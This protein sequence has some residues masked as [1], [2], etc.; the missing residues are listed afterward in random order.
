MIFFKCFYIFEIRLCQ[1]AEFN[2]IFLSKR[3]IFYDRIKENSFGWEDSLMD[4]QKHFS[5]YNTA[6]LH[7]L[8][9]THEDWLLQR[10][11][12][13]VIERGFGKYVPPLIESWRLAIAGVSESILIGLHDL[14]PEFEIGPDDDY[15][16]DPVSRFAILEAHRHRERGITLKMF[17]GLLIYF[18]QIFVDL[19]QYAEFELGYERYSKKIIERLFDRMLLAL[20][21]EWTKYD[22]NKLIEDL[23]A[24]NRLM[25]NEKNKYLSIFESHPHLVFILDNENRIDNMNHSAATLFYNAKLPGSQYYRVVKNGEL[26]IPVLRVSP[27]SSVEGAMEKASSEELFP[28]LA[29]E[30][31]L[32][33][34]GSDLIRGFE[35]KVDGKEGTQYFNVK[36]SR[37]IDARKEIRGIILL[38][39]DITPQK[40]VSEELRQAKE[41]AERANRAKSTF[42]ANM[43]H[44]LRTPLNAILG[45]TRMMMKTPDLNPEQTQN[46]DII[47]NSGEN[48]L[49][50]INN[51]LD[52]SKIE[53]GHI[54][55]EDTDINLP[56]L[57][58]EIQ[59]LLSIR[60][61]EKGLDFDMILSPDLPQ[62]ITVDSGKLRQI[63]TNL[64]ANAVK[65]TEKGGIL[66][67]VMVNR[68][69][70]PNRAWLY[71][72]VVDS[73]IGIR[74]EDQ[75]I[76]FSPF[77]QINGQPVSETGTGLGLAIC[78]QYTELMNGRIG[79]ISEPGKG[80]A[81]HVEIPVNIS[82]GS[83]K[84]FS[85]RNYDRITAVA[86]EKQ[87]YRILIAEDNMENLLLL[88]KLLEPIGFE[89]RE[90]VNGKEA[91]AIYE[92]WHP[93]LIWMDIRMP[94]M[95]GLEA[96][97]RI[98]E[99]K[100]GPETKIIALTAHALEEERIEIL[101]AGC[102][103]FIRKPY[104]DSEIFGILAKQ[105]DIRFV[106]AD[107]KTHVEADVEGMLLQD[108][109]K[110]IPLDLIEN[111]REAAVLLDDE[112]CF[113]AI[114]RI[115]DHNHELGKNLHR[116]V[117]NFKHKAILITLDNL[118]VNEEK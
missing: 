97:R 80:S 32:F 60:I 5:D 116:M 69:E 78:K 33:A 91:V 81:F 68:W 51:I 1:G 25:T 92:Q 38:I 59:S 46:L 45:F 44:E 89:I 98:K 111:L 26:K 61:V 2:L 16:G 22:Q 48:L 52:I 21:M 14:F 49:R 104:R 73:G 113:K 29:D 47:S 64:V 66:L 28:W 76:I 27:E 74:K 11:T 35:K 100:T 72:E 34:E 58:D 77:E 79:V 56:L 103:G 17:M 96:T 10:L 63:L 40:L 117:E 106:F 3:F 101:A 65:F 23:Q 82:A 57:L 85:G 19:I 109:M 88:R 86:E 75:T 18:R 53:A 95:N 87:N 42:L 54:V 36:L 55:I 8:I 7:R 6:D 70:T 41:R 67:K 110:K 20:S 115:H 31:K 84:P 118:I 62:D 71:F 114:G 30:L 24:N 102:D 39:E 37:T 94:V 83:A 4:N 93:H 108:Q 13:Y 99:N 43:S 112:K 15:A 50:L 12:T 105:L 90:A 9:S 107:E